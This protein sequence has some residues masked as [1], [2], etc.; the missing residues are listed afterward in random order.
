MAYCVMDENA[1]GIFNT[2]GGGQEMIRREAVYKIVVEGD[3]E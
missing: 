1:E 2:V 3:S